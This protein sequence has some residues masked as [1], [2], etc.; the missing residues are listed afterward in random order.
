MGALLFY[1]Q[2]LIMS[3]QKET[4]YSPCNKKPLKKEKFLAFSKIIGYTCAKGDVENFSIGRADSK[5]ASTGQNYD[6]SA[7][8]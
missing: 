6:R 5:G 4:G 1:N 8:R 7:Q 3:T 2:I